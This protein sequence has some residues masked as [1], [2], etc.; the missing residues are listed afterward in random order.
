MR[1]TKGLSDHCPVIVEDMKQ[2]E[3]STPFQSLDSWFTHEDFLRMVEEW[4]GLGEIQFTDKLKALTISLGRWHKANFGDMDKKITEFEKE[5]KKIDDMVS[6]G[7]YDGTMEARRKALVTYCERWDG[8]VGRIEQEDSVSL[9]ALPPVE[10]IREAEW[11]CESSKAPS[12]D[13]Y[14]TNFIKRCWEEIG[15]EFAAAVIGFFQTSRLPADSNITWVALALKFI[16]AR[17]IKD[18]RPISMVGSDKWVAIQAVQDGKRLET[19][20]DSIALSHLHFADDTILFYPPKEET[21]KNYKRLLRCFELMSGLIRYLGIPL[22]ANLRLV[23]TWKPIIDK[24]EE[25]LG[26]WKAKMPR[27]VAD[28]L[29][30]LQRRFLWSKE[31]GSNGMALVR[32]KVVQAPKRLGGLGVGEAMVRNTVMLFKWWWQF[33]KEDCPLWKKLVL[34]EAILPEEVTSYN[35]T[36][37]IWKGLVPPRVELFAWFV[38]IGVECLDI[39]VWPIMVYSRFDERTFSIVDREAEEKGE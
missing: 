12:C 28:K 39:D 23:K 34:Q 5:I 6:N 15:S 20:R 18:L 31:N 25:K 13:G 16:G 24:V 21:I 14:N 10:E 30:S 35:F 32:W 19:R 11:D 36:K 17:E 38:L 9:E 3:G 33:A 26:L 29:I 7:V 8:L 27:A 37:T 22:G 2:R 1:W 4:R